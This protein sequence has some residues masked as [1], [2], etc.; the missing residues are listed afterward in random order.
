V[1]RFEAGKALARS[2]EHVEVLSRDL[3]R[4]HLSQRKV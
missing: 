2:V 3:R 4:P 1:A